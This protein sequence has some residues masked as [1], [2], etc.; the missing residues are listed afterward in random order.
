MK[1]TSTL[2]HCATL[3][4]LAAVTACSSGQRSAPPP[5][6]PVRASPVVI[7]DTVDPLP[8]ADVRRQI[9]SHVAA[10]TTSS[11]VRPSAMPMFEMTLPTA[12]PAQVAA[13]PE[14]NSAEAMPTDTMRAIDTA[15]P[16]LLPEPAAAVAT[17]E[18]VATV[19]AT[20]VTTEPE[21]AESRITEAM[22]AAPVELPPEPTMPKRVTSKGPAPVAPAMLTGTVII[23]VTDRAGVRERP[24]PTPARGPEPE[25]ALVPA[26][27]PAPA[28]APEPAPAPVAEPAPAPAPEPT[29]AP[30]A[31]PAPVPAPE[32]T[33]AP[34]AEPA[35]EP[36]PEPT[37]AP[38]AEPAPVPA[39]EPTP[40]PVAEPAPVPAPEPTPAPVAEPAPTPAPTPSP[41][42]ALLKLANPVIASK[43]RAF[44]DIEPLDAGALHA[45]DRFLVYVELVN[46]PF[47]P[48]IGGRVAAHAQYSLRIENL[49]GSSIW[50]EGPLD[51]T[52]S[53]AV[54]TDEL[55]ITRM[56]RLPT[57][58]LAGQYRLAIEA[59]DVATGVTA[60]V[61]TPFTVKSAN[62]H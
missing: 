34:V 18:P 45:G 15:P 32:P 11:S 51:A 28:P 8:Q 29:P 52:H 40:A 23:P 33:P 50:S 55:F 48:G 60:K 53:A 24:A 54:P 26:A 21:V 20:A 13:V 27:E 9:D 31:E 59:T 16:P 2:F 12:S 47:V 36:A 1:Y 46:W 6:T 43:V 35:P 17:T 38:V 57:P 25:P 14:A 62:T 41:A 61:K 56:V 39:P 3:P 7:R 5:I 4:V 10:H 42:P 58:M 30:V 22:P 37:P 44:G 49:A 19:A